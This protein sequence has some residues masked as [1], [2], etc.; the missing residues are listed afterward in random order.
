MM[1]DDRSDVLDKGANDRGEKSATRFCEN[2]VP[3]VIHASTPA[4]PVRAP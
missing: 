1:V 3:T 2:D 4:A